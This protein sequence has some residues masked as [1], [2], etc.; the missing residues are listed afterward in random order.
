MCERAFLGRLT[1]KISDDL[2]HIGFHLNDENFLLVSKKD[3]RTAV[4]GQ[5]AAN[6]NQ[7]DL[8]VHG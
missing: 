2:R 5:D 4:G 7:S 8:S 1:Q 3:G 6:F